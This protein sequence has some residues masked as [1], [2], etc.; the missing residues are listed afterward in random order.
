MSKSSRN[1]GLHKESCRLVEGSCKG[2][3]EWTCEG[4]PKLEKE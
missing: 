1:N 2:Y 3:S 4:S